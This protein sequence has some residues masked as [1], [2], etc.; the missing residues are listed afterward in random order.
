VEELRLLNPRW[1][2]IFS[3]RL[4]AGAA[5]HDRRGFSAL[6]RIHP[7][8]ILS[9]Q[10]PQS[11]YGGSAKRPR[12]LAANCARF[13]YFAPNRTGAGGRYCFLQDR[14]QQAWNGRN[15]SLNQAEGGVYG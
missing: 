15:G 13:L 12:L 2:A 9:L 1:Y 7:D 6:A 11:G 4:E 14:T 10:E 3:A 8:N 5:Q